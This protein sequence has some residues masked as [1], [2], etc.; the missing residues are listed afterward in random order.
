MNELFSEYISIYL[1]Y[2]NEDRISDKVGIKLPRENF[3]ETLLKLREYL[4]D[5][6][7]RGKEY[8]V[9]FSNA[10]KVGINPKGD[11]NMTPLGVYGYILDEDRIRKVKEDSVEYRGDSKYI[12]I[13]EY[14]GNESNILDSGKYSRDDL[15]RDHNK[16]KYLYR[17]KESVFGEVQIS[18][19]IPFK[20]IMLLV[21]KLADHKKQFSYSI[22]V[23]DLGYEMI[24]DRGTQGIHELEPS[25]AVIF[26]PKSYRVLER[27]VNLSEK[28]IEREEEK[29]I[30]NIPLNELNKQTWVVEFLK[31]NIPELLQFIV[32][33]PPEYLKYFVIITT[34]KKRFF[35]KWSDKEGVF[36]YRLETTPVIPRKAGGWS[37]NFEFLGKW[38]GKVWRGG[39]FVGGSWRGG[40]WKN[41]IWKKGG[42][43]DG[44]W[45]NGEFQNGT[46]YN[47]TWKN[48]IFRFGNWDGGI[49]KGGQF[50]NGFWR[51][52]IWE[53]GTWENGTWENGTWEGGIWLKGIWET[54]KI[55]VPGRGV[56]LSYKSPKE[57]FG[58]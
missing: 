38:E 52:G 15:E 55:F 17:E 6:Q 1:N 57:Y 2:L 42:W 21:Y 4:Q 14:T 7:R 11:Y 3:Q 54:G 8:F 47:G 45:E 25:Q 34:T 23:K 48:G 20:S 27:L 12:Y 33:L 50:K 37:C 24:I 56:M 13:L 43:F 36:P 29:V 19:G 40:V 58:K 53:N 35:L 30:L 39:T 51:D 22:F 49:W 28:E 46:W 16:L 44:V 9:H 31:K 10:E 18:L 41:G 32:E 26:Q 5:G